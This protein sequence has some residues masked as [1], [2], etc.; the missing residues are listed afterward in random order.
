MAEHTGR[1][2][3]DERLG[4]FLKQKLDEVLKNNKIETTET[5]QFY[6]WNLLLNPPTAEIDR[7]H[8]KL[9]LAITYNQAQSRGIGSRQSV[10][11][12]KLVGDTCLLVAGFWWNSLAR[13]LVDVDYFVGLG[14]SAYG[15][16][17]QTD[18]ELSEV[19]GE[20]SGYFKEITNALIE[21]SII[22]D[23]AKTS[24]SELLRIYEV[25]AHTH[26]KA[27]ARILAKY[28]IIPSADRNRKI[29]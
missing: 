6:V 2:V 4:Y 10:A 17:S 28:G 3:S 7:K 5:A 1:L 13:S 11:D 21:M 9:P 15:N 29:H 16:V 22:L 18:T 25:W 12:F 20:L 19:L 8:A 27:L 23:I 14:S 26:N 24:D